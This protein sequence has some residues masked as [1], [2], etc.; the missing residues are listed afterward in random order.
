MVCESPKLHNLTNICTVVDF[1]IM[2]GIAIVLSNFYISG[3]LSKS[4][5]QVMKRFKNTYIQFIKV[6]WQ[7]NHG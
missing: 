3:M 7:A 6:N 1:L 5:S 2:D 4:K